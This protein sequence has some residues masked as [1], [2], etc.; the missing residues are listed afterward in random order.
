MWRSGERE[1]CIRRTAPGPAR[2][3]P[4]RQP[5]AAHRR[6][7]SPGSD[8]EADAGR[9]WLGIDDHGKGATRLQHRTAVIPACSA[10]SGRTSGCRARRGSRRDCRRAT[11]ARPQQLLQAR[12]MPRFSSTGRPHRHGL[13]QGLVLHAARPDLQ[14]V[15]ENPRRPDVVRAHDSVPREAGLVARLA[16]ELS[17][18]QQG[19][20]RIWEERARPR[21]ARGPAAATLPL[22]AIKLALD[23]RRRAPP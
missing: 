1:H 12:V 20:E 23:R 17:R 5:S 10:W 15:G 6:G 21:E 7:A 8:E 18:R 14:D 9:A 3:G 19:L 13:Q 2:G 16:Q 4:R 11:S 22:V